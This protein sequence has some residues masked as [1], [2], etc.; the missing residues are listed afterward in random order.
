MPSAVSTSW[1][2]TAAMRGRVSTF[3]S[4]RVG[5]QIQYWPASSSEWNR[6]PA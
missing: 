3:V 2:G 4:V 5:V 1:P 6:P